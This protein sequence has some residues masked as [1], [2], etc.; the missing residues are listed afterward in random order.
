[1]TEL[2]FRRGTADLRDRGGLGDAYRL[3]DEEKERLS[4]S[5]L[6]EFGVTQV[7]VGG[8][9]E[10]IHGC[11]LPFGNHTDQEANPT[12]SLNYEK[13]VYN[14]FGCGSGGSILW[15]IGLM[16]DV[17]TGE[18]R[19]WIES[20]TGLGD[21][22]EGLAVL[23]QYF[24]EVYA[25][26]RKLDHPMPRMDPKVLGPWLMIHP[27]MTEERGVPEST[28]MKFSVGYGEMR[29]RVGD[30]KWVESPRIVIPH[31]W[32]GDLVGWQTRRLI[33]DGTPKY[34]SSSDFPK[35]R[36]LYNYD[37]NSKTVVLVESPLSVL[38]KDHLPHHIE[39][40]F[41]AQIT[42]KQMRLISMHPEVVLFLD[43]DQA[44][45]NATESLGEFLMAYS[46]VWV[47]DNPW[48]ADPADLS[49]EIYMDLINDAVPF[50]LWKRPTELL[51]LEMV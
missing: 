1:M 7:R 36:T 22:A 23:L 20:Q 26:E 43:P 44:G 6:A 2:Q 19:S 38:S 49:D 27:Y 45:W 35:D 15:L 8:R 13:L 42:D 50:A 11:I 34:K 3:P 32:K 17:S 51:E 28:L 12:A 30:Q 40:T 33:R 16:R 18:A 5:L 37:P 39:A 31:F 29:V 48:A 25:P 24:D 10:L 9:G 4:R 21:E 14:C 41:G 46:N 47:V